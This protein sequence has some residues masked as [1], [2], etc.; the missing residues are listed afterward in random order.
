M[1]KGDYVIRLQVRHDK[2]DYLDKINEAPLLLQQKLT[3]GITMDVYLSYS[4][5]L[6]GG[7][8]AGITHNSNPYTVVPLYIA[9]LASDK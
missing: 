2:K 6:I 8:K 1:E 4:Q 5:A 7:K 3:N 9:P